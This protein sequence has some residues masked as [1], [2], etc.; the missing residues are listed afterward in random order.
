MMRNPGVWGTQ[1]EPQAAP[2]Y[3]KMS[4]YLPTKREQQD[5]YQWH[6]YKPHNCAV[7][8]DGFPQIE[9]DHPLLV[10]FDCTVDAATPQNPNFI[11]QLYGGTDNLNSKTFCKI[12]IHA[13]YD[14]Q[15]LLLRN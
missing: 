7:L 14:K 15:P 13:L 11:T 10:H 5:M 8:A 6:L 2:D 1:V 9:F 12:L 3:Y 4:I